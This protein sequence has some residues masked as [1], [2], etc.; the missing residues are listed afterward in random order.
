MRHPAGL[1]GREVLCFYDTPTIFGLQKAF[2]SSS[3]LEA[4]CRGRE[5]GS[6]ISGRD[7]GK[8]IHG[9]IRLMSPLAKA[10]GSLD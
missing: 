10:L 8:K 9:R 2:A 4:L 7:I 6:W 3:S 1:R 5:L